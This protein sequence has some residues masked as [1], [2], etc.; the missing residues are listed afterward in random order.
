MTI[1]T[2]PDGYTAVTPW[3]ISRDTARLIDYV[4]EA[5]GAEEITRLTDDDGRIGHA[6]V[7]IGDAVV[8]MFDPQPGWPPTPASCASTSRTRIRCTA[9]RSR[10][11]GPR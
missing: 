8:M 4:T 5:F 7:R 1:K 11:A 10:P 6:E 9:G 3:L 2:I